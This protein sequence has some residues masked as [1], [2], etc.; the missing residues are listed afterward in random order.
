M[1]VYFSQNGDAAIIG[2][3]IQHLIQFMETDQDYLSEN[4]GNY[5]LRS[6]LIAMELRNC[7]PRPHWAVLGFQHHEPDRSK[8]IEVALEQAFPVIH[9]HIAKFI[10]YDE[11]SYYT[12]ITDAESGPGLSHF[13]F[14]SVPLKMTFRIYVM[15][16]HVEGPNCLG[17]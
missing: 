13:E 7:F 1:L 14:E 9:Q 5:K 4:G 16:S 15:M 2:N 10:D 12:C 17:C 3:K 11:D 6:H 8:L